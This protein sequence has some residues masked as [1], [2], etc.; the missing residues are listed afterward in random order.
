VRPFPEVNAWQRLV[1]T[2]GG[3]KPRWARNGRE[4]FYLVQSGGGTALMSAPIERGASFAAGTPR[5]VLEGPYFFGTI[6][7][8]NTAFRT[9]DVSLDDQRFL[10]IKNPKG[11][12]QAATSTNII[13]VQNWTEELKQL[14]PTK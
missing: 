2:G 7:S 13:V 5:K 3:A 4:L 8:G 9:Y 10:M 6:G 12:E 1:S 11:A 14:A